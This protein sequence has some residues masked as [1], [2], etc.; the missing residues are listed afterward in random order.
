MKSPLKVLV[1]GSLVALAIDAYA[2]PVNN[3]D[4]SSRA[5]ESAQPEQNPSQSSEPGRTDQQ[6]RADQRQNE[7]TAQKQTVND[8]SPARKEYQVPDEAPFADGDNSVR[9]TRYESDSNPF[10]Q[11]ES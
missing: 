5:V 1:A 3:P 7:Q 11:T 2:E 10:P 6:N 8:R 9:H 4:E